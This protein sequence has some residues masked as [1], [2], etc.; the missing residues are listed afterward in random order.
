MVTQYPS[1]TGNVKIWD[2]HDRGDYVRLVNTSTHVRAN[3][4]ASS[5]DLSYLNVSNYN[6]I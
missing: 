6:R 4:L 2:V 5:V 3:V 1:A